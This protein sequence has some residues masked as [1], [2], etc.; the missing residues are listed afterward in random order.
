LCNL[1]EVRNVTIGRTWNRVVGGWAVL[2]GQPIDSLEDLV[3][4]IL[5]ASTF[6][7]VAG[8]KDGESSPN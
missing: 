4:A 5:S 7:C 2:A 1:T 6:L 8:S 3:L